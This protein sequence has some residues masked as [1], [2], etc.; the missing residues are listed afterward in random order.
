MPVLEP[1]AEQASTVPAPQKTTLLSELFGAVQSLAAT[2]AIAIFVITFAVQAFQIP[3]GSMENTLL[4]GDYVLVDKVRFGPSGFW[5]PF[6][7]YRNIARGDVIVFKYPVNPAEHFVKR[8][9][10]VPG[11]RIHL[12]D[13]KVF[14]NGVAMQEDYAIY[15]RRGP[16]AYRDNF[17]NRHFDQ[18]MTQAW[19][20]ELPDL[21]RI[22]DLLV[23]EGHY[24]VLGDNRN[25]SYDSRYWGLVPRENVIGR[26][27]LIYFSVHQNSDPELAYAADGR[28]DGFAA[29]LWHLPEMPRWKR[30]FRFVQ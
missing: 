21:T 7:P 14:V 2:V 26:P 27:L 22:G 12:M 9:I 5:K 8:V 10:G 20:A 13:G 17:P 28:I 3:S 16:S 1:P 23:P 19:A 11:D 4:V 30:T 24:F 18:Q 29:H 25:D 15:K 6:I